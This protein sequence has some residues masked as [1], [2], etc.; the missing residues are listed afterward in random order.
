MLRTPDRQSLE[1]KKDVVSSTIKANKV[2]L[3]ES[4]KN[5]IIT[6]EGSRSI[7]MEDAG[8]L[9]EEEIDEYLDNPDQLIDD[10]LE[11]EN[12]EVTL[13]YLY[14]IFTSD[15]SEEILEAARPLIGEEDYTSLKEQAQQI[16]DDINRGSSSRSMADDNLA[17]IVGGAGVA[18]L[19]SGFAYIFTPSIRFVAKLGCI[20]ACSIAAAAFAGFL[21]ELVD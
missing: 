20:V 21:K 3:A 7:E 9:T 13:D 17:H 12:G 11:E 14:T 1:I 5:G 8:G 15:D 4:L 10:L 2:L 19:V 18:F 16:K 6:A